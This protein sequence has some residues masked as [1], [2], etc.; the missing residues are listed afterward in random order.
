MGPDGESYFVPL[1]KSPPFLTFEEAD[2]NAL[3][4]ASIL[5]AL[6]DGVTT[7]KPFGLKSAPGAVALHKLKSK[8]EMASIHREVRQ[9]AHYLPWLDALG[10]DR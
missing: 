2:A 10:L 8:M 3:K 4:M 9:Q 1:R 5:V 7:V 6:Y